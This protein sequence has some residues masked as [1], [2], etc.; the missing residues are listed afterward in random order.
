MMNVETLT[1]RAPVLDQVRAGTEVLW[2]NPQYTG[3]REVPKDIP[4]TAQD[5]ADADSRL[6]RFAPFLQLR[7]PETRARNG[8]IESPLTEIPV[9]TP[10]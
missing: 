1:E 7:F 10:G 4:L 3:G 5:I 6:Q 9:C 2:L 8:L